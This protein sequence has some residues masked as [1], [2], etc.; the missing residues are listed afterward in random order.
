MR[1]GLQLCLLS[2]ISWKSPTTPM[3]KEI[4]PKAVFERLFGGSYQNKKAQASRDFYRKSILDFVADDARRL[5]KQLGQTD[6]R[7]IDEY[8]QSVR[9]IEA[10]DQQV[11]TPGEDRHA[12]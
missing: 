7:K 3:A 6:R 8:F 9:E 10:A 12:G 1:L 11:R 5:H 4:D 2:N